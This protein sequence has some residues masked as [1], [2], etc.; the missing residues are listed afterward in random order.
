MSHKKESFRFNVLNR[1][2][3]LVSIMQKIEEIEFIQESLKLGR[4]I[5]HMFKN[6]QSTNVSLNRV[7]T[8]TF[9][10]CILKTTEATKGFILLFNERILSPAFSLNRSIY[11]LWAASCFIE[12]AVHDF[13]TSGNEA[14]FA[15]IADKLFAGA[16]YPAKL[17]WGEPSTHKPVHINEMLA[18][19]EQRY[20]GAVDT[21]SF[22][23]EYCHPNFLYNMEA[24]LASGQETLRENPL[25]A[26]RITLAL[27]KQLSSLAQA[28]S[29]TK[30]C[31]AAISDMCLQEYG[32]SYP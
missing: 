12:K 13:R 15:K 18:E 19:L 9:F 5:D 10:N 23:C 6:T 20:A 11:E 21:Y 17:P 2:P 8:Y 27:E 31:T 28:L 24:Y 30:A 3:Q 29:G 14:E 25:F 7:I 22:L 1:V 16:R 4:L 26:E 32:I